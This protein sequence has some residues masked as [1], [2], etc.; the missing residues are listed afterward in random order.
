VKKLVR[1]EIGNLTN[2]RL[3]IGGFR[4]VTPQEMVQLAA[5]KE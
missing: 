2:T 4:K 3:K 5:P 1:T